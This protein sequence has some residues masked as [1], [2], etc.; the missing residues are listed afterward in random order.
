MKKIISTILAISLS[1]TLFTS[2]IAKAE[3]NEVVE[4]YVSTMGSDSNSGTIEEPLKTLE[5]ARDRIRKLKKEGTLAG[6]EAVVYFRGGDYTIT[7]GV[8]FS[9]EDSGEIRIIT[10]PT[11][12]G[13]TVSS[14]YYPK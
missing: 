3:K 11:Q 13:Q 4:I 14:M 10:S 2:G 8:V 7:K 5:G 1:A 6:K 12:Y 9:E